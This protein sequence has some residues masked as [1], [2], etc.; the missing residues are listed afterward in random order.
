[1]T[2]G[3][4]SDQV[5]GADTA[6]PEVRIDPNPA[7]AVF[8]SYA[9]Q[10]ASAA[11][12][13]AGALRA[14]G[15]E[16]WFDQSELRGGDAW[17]ASIRQQIKGCYLFVPIISA[18]TQSRE[19]GYFRREWNLAVARTLDMAEDRAFLLPLIIDDTSDSEARVPGKF[20]EVQW[21]RLPDGVTP[22]AFI[23]RVRRLLSRELP[24]GPAR[25]ASEAARASSAPTTRPRSPRSWRS[26]AALIL[27]IA[28]VVVALGYLVANRLGL[29]KASAQPGAPPGSATQSASATAFNP[30][31]HSVAV[32]PFVNMSGDAKQ[33]YF[34]DGISEELLNALSRLN[35]LEVV[36]RTSSFSFKGQNVDIS[37]IAHKLNVGAVLEGSVRR[38]GNTV[39]ITVQLINAVNGFHLWSQTYD[40][41]LSDILKV[42]TDVANSVAQQLEVKLVGDEAAK[43]EQGGTKNPQAYDAYL[44]GEQLY[45]KADTEAEFREALTLFDK[46]IAFDP[47]YAAAYVRRSLS[48][49]NIF[50]HTSDAHA[51]LELPAQ[52]M[53]AAKRAVILAPELG[54]AHT[55]LALARVNPLVDISAA[56]SEFNLSLAL[57]PG[58]VIVQRSA[59]IFYAEELGRYDQAIEGARRAIDLD[60]QNSRSYEFL[61]VILDQA[62]RYAEAQAIWQ[63]AK[64]LNPK[65]SF[66]EFWLTLT[67]LASGQIEQVRQKCESSSTQ[68]DEEDRHYFLAL[69]YHVIGRQADAERE[70]EQL[71]VLDGDAGAYAYAGIYA[72]WGE[73]EAALQWLMKAEQSKNPT[74]YMLRGDWRLDPV[75]EEPQFKAL[76]ARLNLPP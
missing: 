63:K 53:A 32:L 11:E 9:S 47:D 35:D 5:N 23:D 46:A 26:N 16:V 17:D 37:T 58:S 49:L 21:T 51:R 48:L 22:A 34:S 38:A 45:S 54:E 28:V 73:K 41:Q 50:F 66:I 14:A 8:I 3:G 55:A 2:E 10:D 29:L 6:M 39:R 59:A 65:S 40:R 67:Q 19:E 15:I 64:A 27:A 13:I 52:V 62:R 71:K 42:Q 24:P 61:G 75:R 18:N 30:P 31:P 60:P 56:E 12:R 33:D 43:I 76:M 57:A 72:Q 7:G 20:R 74:V 1:V 44:R 25:T 68:L 36:A 4:A 69:I 70:F